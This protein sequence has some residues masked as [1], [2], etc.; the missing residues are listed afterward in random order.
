MHPRST[1]IP[2]RQSIINQQHP[3]IH[4]RPHPQHIQ[5]QSI[6]QFDQHHSQLNHFVQPVQQVQ[7]VEPIHQV[8]QIQHVKQ[9]HSPQQV[10]LPVIQ[11]IQPQPQLIQS[12][13]Q[14]P[15]VAVTPT[16][17]IAIN[18]VRL[19]DT[20]HA[21]SQIVNPVSQIVTP[22]SQLVTATSQI[23]TSPGIPNQI[24]P[25]HRLSYPSPRAVQN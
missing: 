4:Q 21:S 11:T 6:Q 20:V 23:N 14:L 25:N 24:R 12:P 13:V 5:R 1:I 15:S 16:S 3:V 22:S 9:I 18:N 8:Q 2:Q 10:S 19:N 17:Q 7:R